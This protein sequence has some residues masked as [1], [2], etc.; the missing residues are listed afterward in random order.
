MYQT[1]SIPTTTY[2]EDNTKIARRSRDKF[3]G[4][5][6]ARIHLSNVQLECYVDCLPPSYHDRIRLVHYCRRRGS[7]EAVPTLEQSTAPLGLLPWEW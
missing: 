6:D 4:N 7:G 5:K 3:R 2:T 1:T